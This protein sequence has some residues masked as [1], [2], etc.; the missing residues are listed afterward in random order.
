M[1]TTAAVD[2]RLIILPR[3]AG[4]NPRAR[5]W[6]AGLLADWHTAEDGAGI[7]ELLLSEVFTNAVCH[8]AVDGGH[9]TVTAALWDSRIRVTVW[10][11]DPEF[12]PHQ[13]D[14]E[15]GRGLFLVQE[16]ADAHGAT[17]AGDGKI[18]WFELGLKGDDQV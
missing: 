14:D 12:R 9:T 3:V 18:V 7:A 6:L 10:D 16:L 4:S 11:P 13:L 15:H 1:P 17:K 5:H 8:P 2:T